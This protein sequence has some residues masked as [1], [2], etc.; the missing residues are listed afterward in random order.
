MQ[1]EIR[2]VKAGDHDQWSALWRAYLE[3]YKTELP[4]EVYAASWQR[5]LDPDTQ[6]HS[7]LAFQ[8][9]MA[10][11]LVN[12]LYHKT[13]W[14][15]RD[16]CYLNDLYVSADARGSTHAAGCGAGEVYW[17]TAKDNMTARR[18]YDRVATLTPFIKYKI[19]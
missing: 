5:I 19:A 18:L 4:P 16:R 15:T 8:G 10:I 9:D 2:A 17:L 12:F 13:F 11:G 6:M 1:I 7:A 3:F 14:D